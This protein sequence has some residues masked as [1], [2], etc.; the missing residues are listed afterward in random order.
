MNKIH[1]IHLKPDEL[2]AREVSDSVKAIEKGHSLTEQE[3]ACLK[4]LKEKTEQTNQNLEV[5]LGVVHNLPASILEKME[6]VKSA[7]L[8]ANRL[9]KKISEKE[10]PDMPEADFTKTNE[11]LEE[12]FLK[13]SEEKQE[14]DINITLTLE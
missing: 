4:D 8:V 10:T 5:L 7:N 3:I 2:L 13:L 12:I 14:E 9:L 11:L 1:K 6:Q